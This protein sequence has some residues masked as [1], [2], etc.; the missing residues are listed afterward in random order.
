M[1]DSES[2]RVLSSVFLYQRLKGCSHS[3]WKSV[4]FAVNHRVG[5]ATMLNRTER[6]ANAASIKQCN[7]ALKAF[8]VNLR[9]VLH[10]KE[11]IHMSIQASTVFS[12]VLYISCKCTNFKQ[13]FET[14][15]LWTNLK[16]WNK[17]ITLSYTWVFFPLTDSYALLAIENCNILL[18]ILLY[19]ILIYFYA[20]ITI[21]EI[22]LAEIERWNVAEELY[23]TAFWVQLPKFN[24]WKCIFS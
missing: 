14:W 2:I 3:L 17:L 1:N 8:F 22:C 4:T 20:K 12:T 16:Y 13:S 15:N 11:Q 19:I 24:Y 9:S 7:E 18:I 23:W 5:D 10:C 21:C 6:H